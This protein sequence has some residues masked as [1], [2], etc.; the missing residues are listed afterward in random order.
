[1]QASGNHQVE[2]KPDIVFHPD[3]NAFPD[4]LQI[5]DALTFNTRERRLCGS[6][7]KR[8]EDTHTFEFFPNNSRFDRDPVRT[9]VGQFRH[10]I[11]YI[12]IGELASGTFKQPVVEARL[13]MQRLKAS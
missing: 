9:D 4:T 5:S 13:D 6:Q 1:M 8:A 7:K 2:H 3:G 11:H 10:G 12:G